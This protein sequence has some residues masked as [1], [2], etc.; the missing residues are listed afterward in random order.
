MN[1]EFK[2][3]TLEEAS[4]FLKIPKSTLYAIVHQRKIRHRKHGRRLAFTLED[5]TDYSN[6]TIKQPSNY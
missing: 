4:D 3:F 1:P 5:L 6:N 2:L